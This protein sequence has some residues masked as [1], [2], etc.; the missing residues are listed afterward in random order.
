MTTLALLAPLIPGA[1]LGEAAL[2]TSSDNLIISDTRPVTL[3]EA[4]HLTLSPL[5]IQ[6]LAIEEQTRQSELALLKELAETTDADRAARIVRRLERLEVDMRLQVL[7]V[8]MAHARKT[9][10]FDLAL[11][12]RS[13][14]LN[15]MTR[16]LQAMK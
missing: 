1:A 4:T 15:L 7:E 14:I 9:G 3:P 13:E 16:D 2:P 8:R 12:L 5:F 11:R 6:I 10:H